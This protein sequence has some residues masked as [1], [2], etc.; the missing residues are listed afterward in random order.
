MTA[1]WLR[2]VAASPGEAEKTAGSA[3]AVTQGFQH[4]WR[5]IQRKTASR[6]NGQVNLQRVLR[7]TMEWPSTAR[8]RTN[9]LSRSPRASATTRSYSGT[10]L[11][12]SL[13][14]SPMT[15]VTAVRSLLLMC[16]HAPV[17][18]STTKTTQ[19]LD[20]V[21]VHWGRRDR[22]NPHKVCGAFSRCALHLGRH[23]VWH[24][25]RLGSSA[26]PYAGYKCIQVGSV[27]YSSY[28]VFIY[29]SSVLFCHRLQVDD[30]RG[31]TCSNIL[32]R[33]T[34]SPESLFLQCSSAFSL[35]D[36]NYLLLSLAYCQGVNSVPP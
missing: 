24:R 27:I 35:S 19:F 36:S 23:V 4:T 26:P 28:L 1:A 17:F 33:R 2:L 32:H 13:S 29:W 20:E 7:S 16:A 10:R 5:T 9:E 8:R 25:M 3:A 18:C 34:C 22:W 15:H 12:L 11:S 6:T 21:Q 31:L 30:Q 14:H